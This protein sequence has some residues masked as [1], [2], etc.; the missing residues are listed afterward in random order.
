MKKLLT[1]NQAAL[2]G[3]LFTNP[4][5]AFYM[6][7]L[8]RILGKKPGFFQRTLN[9][10][11]EEGVLASEYKANARY[12]RAN[13]M[14]PFY[15]ELR[16]IVEKSSGVEGELRKL[17]SRIKTIQAAWIYGSFAKK[18]ERV[19]SDIDL[20]IVGN[21]VAEELLL[22]EFGRMEKALQ[23]E[24]N[25]RFYSGQEYSEKRKQGDPFLDEVLRGPLIVLKGDPHAA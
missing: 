2:L 19:D 4:E 23:R 3:I 22:K 10:L 8:G 9:S 14:H 15:A 24:I 11:V 13:T 6:Q 21:P 17:L 1:K 16:K 12:F 5:K 20:M 7:E 25:Y 18:T